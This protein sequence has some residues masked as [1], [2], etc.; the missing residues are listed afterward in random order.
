MGSAGGRC[1]LKR[2]SLFD[3][4]KQKLFE[5]QPLEGGGMG[6]KQGLMC[7]GTKKLK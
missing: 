5:G 6:G 2:V 1:T 7:L 4:Y 3:L